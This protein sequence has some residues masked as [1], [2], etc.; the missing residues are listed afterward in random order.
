VYFYDLSAAMTTEVNLDWDRAVGRGINMTSDGAIALLNDGVYHK[1]ARYTKHGATWSREWITGENMRNCFGF[2]IGDDD[3]T[4]VY[5]YSTSSTPG[6]WYR[7]RLDGAKITAPVQLTELNP[8]YKTKTIAKTEVLHWKGANDDDVE[9]I[10]YYPLHYEAGKKYPLITATHGGPA[11]ADMDAWGENWAYSQNLLTQRGAFL[12]K[13]NYHGSSNYGLKWVESIC[14]G[15]YYDLETP[16]IEKGVDNLIAKGLVD[17][18]KIAALGWSNGSILSIELI[19]TNPDRYKAAV[20]GA[21]DV[22]WISDWANVDFGES[23]D[24]YYFGKTPLEDPE[25]YIRKSP[26]FKLDGVKTPTLI[27][28]G[29]NDRQVP[30]AQSWTFYRAMYAIGKAPAK[31]VLFPGEAH[32]PRKL[33]HQLRKVTEEMAWFDK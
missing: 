20:V 25:L 31:L 16:D 8:Q 6:Q 10:L 14:C 5:E 22:E 9:G 12:L 21:G 3:H 13:T 19:V 24:H 28:H 7:A 1:P 32:G 11:A 29:T 2:E 4:V 23:F 26:L 17:P 27:F 18:D 30:T 33:S 15:K